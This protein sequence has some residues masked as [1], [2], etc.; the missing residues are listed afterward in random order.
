MT[1]KQEEQIIWRRGKLLVELFLQDMEPDFF[2][3][4]IAPGLI[5][6]Y[7]I[8]FIN[9]DGGLNQCAIEVKATE[10][11]ID[12]KCRIQRSV[13]NH[14]ANSNIPVFLF[15]V[16]VKQNAIFYAR[17]TVN[18]QITGGT[19]FVTIPVTLIDDNSKVEIRKMMAG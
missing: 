13:F 2:V 6:D 10:Q 17:L 11:T 14:L 9:K 15:V 4:A 1:T 5:Y 8:G 12:N 7:L 3:E 19:Q 16:D 18:L